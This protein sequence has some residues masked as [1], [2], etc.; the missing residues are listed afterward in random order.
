MTE[1]ET[2]FEYLVEARDT[3]QRTAREQDLVDGG[4][5]RI[6]YRFTLYDAMFTNHDW[7]ESGDRS[8]RN[9]RVLFNGII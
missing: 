7:G 2:A 9:V 1:M 6:I 8:D 5:G 4:D 3:L